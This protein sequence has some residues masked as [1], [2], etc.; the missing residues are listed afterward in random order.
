MPYGG[1]C[2]DI[3]VLI[4]NRL[5]FHIPSAL[6]I[7]SESCVVEILRDAGPGGMDVVDIAAKAKVNPVVLS[8]LSGITAPEPSLHLYPRPCTSTVSYSLRLQG[9]E[10]ICIVK[11]S[12]SHSLSGYTQRLRE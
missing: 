6:R 11:A 5:Q 7:A 3:L 1:R 9:G 10:G 2:S 12:R 8:T 4:F